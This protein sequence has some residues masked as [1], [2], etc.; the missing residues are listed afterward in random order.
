M[1]LKHIIC[2]ISGA[3]LV[4][5]RNIGKKSAFFFQPEDN[6][7][8]I[9]DSSRTNTIEFDSLPPNTNVQSNFQTITKPFIT[10]AMS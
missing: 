10:H 4:V 7:S 6:L 5:L 1:L 2:L 9:T 3:K 8:T